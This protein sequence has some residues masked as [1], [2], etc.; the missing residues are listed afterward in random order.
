[1]RPILNRRGACPS[2]AAPML[3][4]DGLLVRLPPAAM[5][6]SA[7][8]ALGHA[9][10]AF[11]NGLLDITA[12]GSVQLRGLRAENLAGLA[13]ALPGDWPQSA[14]VMTSPLAGEDPAEIADPRPLA[15]RITA[16][17]PAGLA[18]KTTV[19]VDGGGALHL[20]SQSADLRLVACAEGWRVECGGV[21]LGTGSE[22]VATEAALA[23]LERMARDGTRPAARQPA[24]DVAAARDPIG[25][26]PLHDGVALGVAFPYGRLRAEAL[27]AFAQACDARALRGAPGRALVAL[28][29]AYPEAL[30]TEAARLGF[31]TDP[32][33][34]RRRIVACAGA[35]GCASGLINTHALAETLVPLL[36]PQGHLHISGCA[37]GCAHPGPAVLTLVGLEGGLGVVRQGRACAPLARRIA[38]EDAA[39]F[40]AAE[41]T[42]HA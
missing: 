18:P 22:D 7:W 3:T 29:A 19:L 24:E 36:P 34:P 38:L 6:P 11:G 20:A 28:G 5:P 23:Q 35:P 33:D 2:L 4:G 8:V 21:D 13:G 40:I 42:A 9:A 26:H 32:A 12:R 27:I 1:M 15:A 41:F 25:P 39:S 10:L 16:A 17:A 37:K 30:R 31:I 14:L